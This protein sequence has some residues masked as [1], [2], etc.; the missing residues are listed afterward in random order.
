MVTGLMFS[1]PAGMGVTLLPAFLFTMDI[2]DTHPG[3]AAGLARDILTLFEGMPQEE[4][5]DVLS[6]LTIALVSFVMRARRRLGNNDIERQVLHWI[7]AL[8]K[9][10]GLNFSDYIYDGQKD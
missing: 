2:S 10:T 6:G 1:M 5:M 7:A 9:V 4:I 3:K 8:D